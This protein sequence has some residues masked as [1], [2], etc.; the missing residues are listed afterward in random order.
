MTTE[1]VLGLLFMLPIFGWLA[2]AQMPKHWHSLQGLLLVSYA[3]IPGT[4]A[5]IALV[6]SMP[7]LLF[8]ALFLLGIAAVSR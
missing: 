4:L 7:A 3:I 8:G 2:L 1:T 5:I 6:V